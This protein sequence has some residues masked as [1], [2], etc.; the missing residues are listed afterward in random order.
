MKKPRTVPATYIGRR[1]GKNDSTLHAFLIG[2]ETFYW[3]RAHWCAIGH[4]YEIIVRGKNFALPR[5][6]K[7]L[8]VEPAGKV[9]IRGWEAQ[10][11]ATEQTVRERLTNHKLKKSRDLDDIARM[12]IPLLEDVG[13]YK[14]TLAHALV[15]RAD[16]L[17]R[18]K[19]R[20]K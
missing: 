8:D 3:S 12:L 15:R 9:L 20:K 13:F 4:Q 2:K 11:L 17:R 10:D 1:L 5:N 7:R 19:G 16:E 6:P 18:K 14:E